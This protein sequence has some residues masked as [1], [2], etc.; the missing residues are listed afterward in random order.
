MKLMGHG[1]QVAGDFRRDFREI[2][3]FIVLIGAEA[4]DGLFELVETDLK[5]SHALADVVMKFP[6]DAG[7][8]FFLSVNQA[9]R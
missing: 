5:K 3:K 7:A 1:V 8:F 4:A 9:S 2:V 6:R